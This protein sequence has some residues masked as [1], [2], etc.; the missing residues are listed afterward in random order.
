VKKV[1]SIVWIP[2][3][4]KNEYCSKTRSE[5]KEMAKGK[6]TKKMTKEQRQTRT[7][8]VVFIVISVI[9]LFTMLMS[10]IVK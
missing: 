3:D 1:G 9:V 2:A 10:L 5:E 6:N 4:G 7:Y 8:R